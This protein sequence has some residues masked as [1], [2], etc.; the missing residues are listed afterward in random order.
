MRKHTRAPA[1]EPL[2]GVKKNYWVAS[3]IESDLS[4][5]ATGCRG[6]HKYYVI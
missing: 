5:K 2:N 3:P 6:K 4:T 1:F